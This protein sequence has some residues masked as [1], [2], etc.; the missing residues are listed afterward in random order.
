MQGRGGHVGSRAPRLHCWVYIAVPLEAVRLLLGAPQLRLRACPALGLHTTLIRAFC[1]LAQSH[2]E[3][4]H[5]PA[6]VLAG[7][8][9]H[10]VALYVCCLA[11]GGASTL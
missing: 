5:R 9:M 8:R 2:G 1:A 4:P 11:A 3:R 6:D 10:L 7:A